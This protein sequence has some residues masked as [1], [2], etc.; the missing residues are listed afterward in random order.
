MDCFASLA[1]TMDA[2]PAVGHY[3]GRRRKAFQRPDALFEP[4]AIFGRP[5]FKTRV[6]AEI[7]R[8]M[9]GDVGIELRLAAD[10]DEIGLPVLQDRLGLLRL[11]ND[12]DRH[13]RDIGL[14]ADALR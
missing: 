8:P 13:G 3:A 14:V 4:P 6:D 7:V 11:E 12:A 5:V 9:V 1:M 2:S 10:R